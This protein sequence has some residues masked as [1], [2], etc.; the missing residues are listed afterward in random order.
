MT[1]PETGFGSEPNW[2]GEMCSELLPRSLALVGVG[3]VERDDRLRAQAAL[4]IPLVPLDAR[5][6]HPRSGGAGRGAARVSAPTR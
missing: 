2:V 6:L 1:P 4:E 5:H 3:A